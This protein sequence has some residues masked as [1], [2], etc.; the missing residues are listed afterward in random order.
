MPDLIGCPAKVGRTSSGI[1][2]FDGMKNVLR[3]SS[4]ASEGGATQFDGVP[5]AA[6]FFP[7]EVV[8]HACS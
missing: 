3:A 5:S 1:S 6:G 4:K 2:S 8:I 7:S